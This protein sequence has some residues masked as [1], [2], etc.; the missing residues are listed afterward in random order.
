MNDLTMPDK[1]NKENLT[2][3]MRMLISTLSACQKPNGEFETYEIIT[4][5]YK[6]WQYSGPSPFI[7]ANILYCLQTVN[8]PEAKRMLARGYDFLHELM[9]YGGYW[10]FW[11]LE[12]GHDKVPLDIDDTCVCSFVLRMANH[13]ITRNRYRILKNMD[14]SGYFFT[15]IIPRE[16]S[17]RYFSFDAK[18]RCHMHKYHEAIEHGM[19]RLD[20]RE[21]TVAANALLYL[22]ENDRTI[23][24]IDKIIDQVLNGHVYFQYYQHPSVLYYNISRAFANGVKRFGRLGEFIRREIKENNSRS[25]DNVFIKALNLCTLLNYGNTD[26]AVEVQELAS[27]TQQDG[28][29]IYPYFNSKNLL[30]NAGSKILTAAVCL[31]AVNGYLNILDKQLRP[32]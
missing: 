18:L 27:L 23:R 4:D 7:H 19:L 28:L 30:F 26:L 14:S 21:P 2:G 5:R 31:E 1:L 17:W 22:G 24:C 32:D 10:R 11:S 29:K 12:S 6:D 9:E 8:I 16:F 3:L 25:K 20:D 13:S 15:W